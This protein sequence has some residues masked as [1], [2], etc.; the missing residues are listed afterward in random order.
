MIGG[1]FFFM[2]LSF[3]AVCYPTI[4]QTVFF[5][6]KPLKRGWK[7]GQVFWKKGKEEEFQKKGMA[8]AKTQNHDKAR[9]AWE[10]VSC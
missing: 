6:K 3:G 2:L 9:Q 1:F 10:Q 5:T 7:D 4:D 8:Y